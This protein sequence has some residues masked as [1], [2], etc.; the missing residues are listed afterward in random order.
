MAKLVMSGSKPDRVAI[1]SIDSARYLFIIGTGTE[2]INY[3]LGY[4][5]SSSIMVH[6]FLHQTELCIS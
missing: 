2:M 4:I 5:S 6:I 1:H 3:M